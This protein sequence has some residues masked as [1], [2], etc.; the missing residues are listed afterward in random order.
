ML[1]CKNRGTTMCTWRSKRCSLCITTPCGLLLCNN[2][3]FIKSIVHGKT[4][5]QKR[6]NDSKVSWIGCARRKKVWDGPVVE[7]ERLK[8]GSFPNLHFFSEVISE[9]YCFSVNLWCSDRPNKWRPKNIKNW[10]KC[11]PWKPVQTS[12]TVN[13]SCELKAKN[14]MS[15]VRSV[16]TSSAMDAGH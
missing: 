13:F 4:Q 14:P 8:V 16:F 5:E 9:N 11:E 2:E 1:H 3:K 15:S 10:I 12:S 6:R 7:S